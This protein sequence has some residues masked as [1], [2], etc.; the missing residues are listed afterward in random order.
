MAPAKNDVPRIGLIAGNGQFPIIFSQA[1]KDRGYSVVALAHLHETD[2][3]IDSV[4]DVV[5]WVKLGQLSRIINVFKEHNVVEAVLA[6]G[7]TKERMFS[8]LRPDFR[9]LALLAKMDTKLDDG[10]LRALAGELEKEGIAVKSPDVFMPALLVE[11]GLLTRRRPT[12]AE[13]RDVAFGW[14]IAKELGR[15]D[16]GQCVVVRDQVVLA[17]EAIEGTDKT[18]RRGGSLGREKVVVVKAAKPNQDLRFDKPAVGLQ[19]IDTM[20]EVKAAVLVIEA[21]KTLIFDRQAMTKAADKAK[22]AIVALTDEAEC[23]EPV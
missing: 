2:P 3:A 1:V 7:I 9:T 13:A 20:A 23:L 18:I 17:V 16:I 5:E 21:H 8:K 10:L 15:L 4:A 11:P 6:G 22:I 12:S 19:T 14:R